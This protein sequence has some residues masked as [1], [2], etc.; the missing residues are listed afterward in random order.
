M[1]LGKPLT[2]P[3]APPP[4]TLS[5]DAGE[6]QNSPPQGVSGAARVG[7]GFHDAAFGVGADRADCTGEPN[8]VGPALDLVAAPRQLGRDLLRVAAFEVEPARVVVVRR[9]G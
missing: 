9:K 2:R 8:P 4:G 5:R 6:G 1:S 3:P 7:A